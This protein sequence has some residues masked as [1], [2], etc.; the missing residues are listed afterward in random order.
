MS[1]WLWGA[2]L[3]HPRE[4]PSTGNRAYD[5]AAQKWNV[6]EHLW[7]RHDINQ[8]KLWSPAG[9][10]TLPILCE[11]I[12]GTC[13]SMTL[14]S[15]HLVFSFKR[16]QQSC[17]NS[18]PIQH[19]AELQHDWFLFQPFRKLRK[20][21]GLHRSLIDTHFR[22]LWS[23]RVYSVGRWADIK[24]SIINVTSKI[25]K[26]LRRESVSHVGRLPNKVWYLFRELVG[27]SDHHAVQGCGV[28]WDV[29]E[30]G[31]HFKYSSVVGLQP[32]LSTI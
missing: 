26:N 16:G 8:L 12:M 13:H 15:A 29:D 5:W 25:Y 23:G 1:G 17:T 19:S 27:A 30:D 14:H 4:K 2:W 28:L 6:F 20:L 3:S 18:D 21:V 11:R 31:A 10:F 7:R 32:T 9:F 22:V 24:R